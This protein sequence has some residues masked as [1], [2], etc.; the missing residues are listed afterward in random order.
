MKKFDEFITYRDFGFDDVPFG[1]PRDKN[2]HQFLSVGSPAQLDTSGLLDI[3]FGNPVKQDF[4]PNGG[5]INFINNFN[6]TDPKFDLPKPIKPI[7]KNATAVKTSKIRITGVVKDAKTGETLPGASVS[8]KN[9]KYS[10]TTTDFDGKFSIMAHPNETMLVS[11]LGYTPKTVSASELQGGVMLQNEG[12]STDEIIVHAK[13]DKKPNY[14]LW[15]LGTAGV[16]TLGY[17]LLKPTTSIKK[18]A[19][20]K[21]RSKGL[22]TWCG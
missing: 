19:P 16:L 10:G 6:F 13:L 22:D 8:S 5:E 9:N 4:P 17:I 2:K 15:G 7:F 18:T 14:L 12:L 3:K 1:D 11:F 21:R 20:K